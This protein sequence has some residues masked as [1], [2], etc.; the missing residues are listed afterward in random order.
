MRFFA[1]LRKLVKTGS[2][3]NPEKAK[4]KLSGLFYDSECIS[5]FGP[6]SDAIFIDRAMK[7]WC[8]DHD[9]KLLKSYNTAIFSA[10]T[11][12]DF[13]SYLDKIEKNSP[14]E[15]KQALDLVYPETFA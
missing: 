5:V 9:A 12:K 4:R 2:Y 3:K 6:Y 10:A 7:H 15:I 8:E 13:H 1:V 11:W 14:E